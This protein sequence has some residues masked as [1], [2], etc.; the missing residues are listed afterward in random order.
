[1]TEAEW[2]A[3]EDP[4]PMLDYLRGP[5]TTDDFSGP[6]APLEKYLEPQTSD[7]KLRLFAVACCRLTWDAMARVGRCNE[8]LWPAVEVAERYADGLATAEELRV[9]HDAAAHVEWVFADDAGTPRVEAGAVR[10]TAS[11]DPIDP[12]HLSEAALTSWEYNAVHRGIWAREQD[13]R[14]PLE[15]FYHCNLVRDIF[16]NPF[17]PITLDP[18]WLTST[19]VSLAR[20]MYES[21]DFSPMPI[22]ADALQ[23]AGCENPDILGHCQGPGPHVRGCFVIDL[24]LGKT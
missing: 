22:L 13:E 17:R 14:R 1:M 6:H 18:E 3:C 5:P 7:R 24:L 12:R 8:E 20:S 11:V 4:H 15:R 16:G 19:V 10:V 2:L 21:R 9:V 23:D